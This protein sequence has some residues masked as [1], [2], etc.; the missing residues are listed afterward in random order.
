[1]TGA[2]PR[3]PIE[4]V[5]HILK[6]AL[7]LSQPNYATR[8][9][10]SISSFALASTTF[11]QIALRNYFRDITP[12]TKTH[13]ANLSRILSAQDER[14]VARGGKGVFT[15]VRCVYAQP[16]GGDCAYINARSL[17]TSSR[18]LSHRPRILISLT[19][20]Q[21][22][23]IDLAQEGLSTQHPRLQTLL[24]HLESGARAN[25]TSLTLSCL[26]RIDVLLLR[27]IAKS[28]P[29]L[30]NLYLSCTERLEFT[31]C[32]TCF[33]DSLGCTIHSPIPD[34]YGNVAEL[35]VRYLPK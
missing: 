22:L 26:P 11:R 33:E 13:W 25:L 12:E 1:M 30:T 35:A 16:P 31:C 28:F 8:Q 23:S 19:Q 20:L 3:V 24:G 17:C 6:L 29:R 2:S 4:I 34:D 32:W 18:I 7:N 21:F 10:S 9:F 5:D 14:E 27:L 15:C